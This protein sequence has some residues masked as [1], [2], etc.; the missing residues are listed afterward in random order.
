MIEV[1]IATNQN[2]N[3]V[4][5]NVYKTIDREVILTGRLDQTNDFKTFMVNYPD[6]QWQS[7]EA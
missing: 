6:F 7:R 5:Q 4:N 2:Q 1:R 3:V